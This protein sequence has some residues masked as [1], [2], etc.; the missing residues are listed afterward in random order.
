[1]ARIQRKARRGRGSG[2]GVSA[3]SP[4]SLRQAMSDLGNGLTRVDAM[5]DI[6]RQLLREGIRGGPTAR[7]LSRAKALLGRT[8]TVKDR[9]RTTFHGFGMIVKDILKNFPILSLPALYV[10]DTPGSS[11]PA[12]QRYQVQWVSPDPEF[13]KGIGPQLIQVRIASK[14]DGY[15]G[16]ANAIPTWATLSGS[17]HGYAQAGIGI[18]YKPRHALSRVTF[19]PEAQIRYQWI[20]DTDQITPTPRMRNWGWLQLFAQRLNPVSGLWESYSQR[21]I[22]VWRG[23]A[24]NWGGP[25][26]VFVHESHGSTQAYPGSD[27][28]LQVIASS[29]DTL[30]FWFV[31]ETYVES[32]RGPTCMNKLEASVPL[33]WVW[34]ES[35]T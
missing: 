14:A 25:S 34:D 4:A 20:I 2:V 35:L 33:M 32:D 21:N 10:P 24:G 7:R 18:V 1:M 28:G 31:V 15:V 6:A 30:L 23:S 16:V 12:S 26:P 27:P 17:L 19:V 22:E 3:L 8:L 13:I 29:A 9:K 11:A 5:D